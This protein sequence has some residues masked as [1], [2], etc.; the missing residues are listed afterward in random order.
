MQNHHSMKKL[1]YIVF[2]VLAASCKR[3]PLDTYDAT[4]NVY[5]N[6]N[7]GFGSYRDTLDFSFADKDV[8]V[9]DFYLVLPVAVTGPPSQ[10]DPSFKLLV[11]PASTAVAGTHYELPPPLIHA[12]RVQDTLHILFKRTADLSSSR[13]KLILRLENN[14]TFNTDLKYRVV[15]NPAI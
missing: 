1:I 11:D 7:L 14:E 10:T 6:Y 12:G 13:K 15:G 8:A 2:V 4:D 3:E 9:T 5:F